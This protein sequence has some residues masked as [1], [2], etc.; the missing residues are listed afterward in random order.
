[1]S[2]AQPEYMGGK[3]HSKVDETLR[4]A[5]FGL[6]FCE[7]LAVSSLAAPLLSPRAA[8]ELLAKGFESGLGP[9]S[10]RSCDIKTGGMACGKRQHARGFDLGAGVGHGGSGSQS[11]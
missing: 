5:V 3:L 1:M 6:W 4:S 9:H 8:R 2:A 10:A 7:F 11:F